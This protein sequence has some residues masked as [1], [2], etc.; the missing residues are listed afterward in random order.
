MPPFSRFS[1]RGTFRVPVSW[2][3]RR[4]G[5][6]F[7]V[8]NVGFQT[9][10]TLSSDFILPSRVGV[11]DARG[12]DARGNDGP[13]APHH[14]EGITRLAPQRRLKQIGGA[15][16]LAV[17]EKGAGCPILARFVR[18]GG[19]P[20]PRRA[21]DLALVFDFGWRCDS[22]LLMIPVIR[23]DRKGHGFSHVITNQ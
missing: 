5:A 2:A 23:N 12:N 18:K 14:T 10:C 22:G 16:L 15:P 13:G 9:L 11:H 4:S 21:R 7:R 1:R 20:Q 17:F 19:I 6:T 3:L 8:R